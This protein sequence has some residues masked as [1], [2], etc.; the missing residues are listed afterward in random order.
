MCTTTSGAAADTAAAVASASRMSTRKSRDKLVG[1]SRPLE[2]A[3]L[4]RV[5][6]Q[7]GHLVSAAEQEQRKPGPF[8]PGMP[9]DQVVHGY[10]AASAMYS[11]IESARK[12]SIGRVRPG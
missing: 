2:Q 5:E 1:E 10:R 6:G 8:E 4:G 12:S 3:A 7:A 9:G 11:R